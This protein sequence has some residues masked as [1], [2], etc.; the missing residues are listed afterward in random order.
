[1][2]AMTTMLTQ[3]LA[4]HKDLLRSRAEQIDSLNSQIRESS[5]LQKQEQDEV[6]D[7]KERVRLRGERYAKIANLRRS[8]AEKR[9][10]L[11]SQKRSLPPSGAEIP[12][13]SDEGA[14]AILSSSLGMNS[15]LTASQRSLAQTKLPSHQVLQSQLHAYLQHSQSLQRQA[16]ELQSRSLSVEAMYRKVV[17][18]C[19]GVEESKVEESLPNLVAAVESEKNGVGIGEV[20]RVREFLRRVDGVGGAAGMDGGM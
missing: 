16:D 9:Q 10:R 14:A 15:S 18:L 4:T 20:G 11:S 8:I 13:L 6:N 5:T 3:S 17:A 19:T 12:W 2:T 7:L 1:M